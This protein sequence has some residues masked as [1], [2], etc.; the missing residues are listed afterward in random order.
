MRHITLANLRT[1]GGRL[2]AAGIAV[3][4][5]VAFITAV[6]ALSQSFNDAMRK[7]AEADAAG[8]QLIVGYDSSAGAPPE[9]SSDDPNAHDS[10]TGSDSA[11]SDSAGSAS[12][13]LSTKLAKRLG[14]LDGVESA[15][16]I[17]TTYAQAQAGSAKSALGLSTYPTSRSMTMDAGTTPA[18][19][20]QIALYASDAK[21]LGASAGDRIE[22]D[23]DLG[24]MGGDSAGSA[25][26]KK[27]YTV[28]GVISDGE[29]YGTAYLTSAGLNRIDAGA[30]PD[31]IRLTL[32]GNQAEDPA[33]LTAAQQRV[34][35]AIADTAHGAAVEDEGDK[36]LA[37]AGLSVQ[38]N[39]QL[40]G[41][42]MESLT[43]SSNA[44]VSIVLA[45]AAIAIIV[46]ALVISN[47]FQVLVASRTRSLALMRAIGATRGQIRAATLAEGLVLGVLGSIAGLLL[48]WAGAAGLGLAA[49]KL[50]LP[51]FPVPGLP[52]TALIAGPAV[53]IVVTVLA[54]IVP[55]RKATRVSPIQALAPLDVPAPDRRFPWVR[56][57]LGGLMTAAGLALTLT[58]ALLHSLLPAF[59][60]GVLAFFGVLVLS[61][62]IVPPLIEGCG[63][64]LEKLTGGS[65]TAGLVARSVRMAP[66]RAAS[67]TTA[68]LIG[69]TLVAT[70]VVGAQT[71]KT[72]LSTELVQRNAVDAAATPDAAKRAAGDSDIV[73]A[74]SELAGASA[75]A[76]LSGEGTDASGT[77]TVLGATRDS[78]SA[79]RRGNLV[80]ERGEVLASTSAIP[81]AEVDEG[82]LEG[83]RITLRAHGESVLL[84]VRVEQGL[85]NGTVLA[86]PADIAPLDPTQGNGQTWL[87]I[88]DDASPS[89]VSQLATDLQAAHPAAEPDLSGAMQR[90]SYGQIID[91][92]LTIVLVLLAASVVIAIV[93]VGNT[94]SMS[95]FERTREAALLRAMGMSRGSVG[96]LITIEAV[97][98]GVVALVLGLALGAFFGWAGTSALLDLDGVTVVIGLP[99]LQ[100]AAIVA[101]AL[102]AAALASALPARRISRI[103]PAEGLTR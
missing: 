86:D 6:L 39:D 40:V 4:V 103:V 66:R 61:R 17:E 96:A 54:C 1:G 102:A 84:R 22:L 18:G 27:D 90:A 16:L 83:A 89:Q 20:D 50:W 67:T 19:K 26:T 76:A 51:S 81:D 53:G 91:I 2:I 63:R 7:Q 74:R 65:P 11:G 92:M 94:L 87:R 55:A 31:S 9:A 5:S 97:L 24:A 8:A 12:A 101:A 99:W 47:T 49:Q 25:D 38:T 73:A 93:G 80:P 33:A 59:G 98:M 3:M 35:H 75:K 32:S 72:T 36:G 44:L 100:L 56:A 57:I 70:M 28:S 23:S 37:V 46:A 29:G 77:T 48:G 78:T 60:G 79:A 68:L 52:W 45:F 41:Q 62:V 21:T 85:P 71:L 95:V 58:G 10:A 34:A 14:R 13:E 82:E 43:G 88:A 42:K 30:S 64:L 69:V 15:Q